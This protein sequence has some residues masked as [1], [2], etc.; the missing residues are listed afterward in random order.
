MTF[1][2]W[3]PGLVVLAATLTLT[4]APG[5]AQAPQDPVPSRS[6]QPPTEAA[7]S[8]E[9]AGTTGNSADWRYNAFLDVGHLDSFND[10]A[11]HLFRNRG[12]T[13]RVDEWDVNMAGASLAKTA[14][15]QSRLGLELTVQTGEDS[16]TFGFSSTAPKIGGADVL[17]HFGP[18]GLSYLAPIGKGL[19]I[20]GGI[21]SSLIGYD[22]LY[23]KDNFSY[24]RPWGA[25]YTP[26][27]M[28]GVNASY[29]ISRK[30]SGTL[31][32]V[33]GYWH[34]A[35]ANN[36]P[37]IVGQLAYKASSRVALRETVL[38]GSHQ[39]SAAL[40]FWRVLSDTIVERRTARLATA[41]EYQI[42]SEKV[43][44]AGTPRAL[45]MSAQLPLHWVVSGPW[46]ITVRPE[47]AWDRDGRWIA[48]R[49]GAGQ[50]VKAITTTIEYRVSY[51]SVQ[52][53]VRLEHRYDD[54]RGASGGF[55][56]DGETA[57]GAVGV[58]P[59][60]HLLILGLI[61]TFD[62]PIRR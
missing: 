4:S 20:Q 27:L 28:L 5:Y 47:F 2:D 53:A 46:S 15:E 35:H 41:F 19:T 14:S 38:Y 56:T 25:D 31:A 1:I 12:T 44:T 57:P 33:N 10:P 21:F 36:V 42:G 16:R 9:P 51:R 59:G 18:T 6:A 40:R 50:S 49:L 30:L 7:E 54:G 17:R 29:P 39:P 34:L 60:Q 48:G 22:S 26:F 52:A 61:L 24:T 3:K 23:A 58:M 62:S 11:N 55:F 13:P 8:A 45:W 32:V 43:D 37:S